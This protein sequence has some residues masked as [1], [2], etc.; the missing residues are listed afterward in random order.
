MEAEIDRMKEAQ[1]RNSQVENPAQRAAQI[2]SI[3]GRYA[4]ISVGIVQSAH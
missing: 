2:K 1:E 3:E 4:T